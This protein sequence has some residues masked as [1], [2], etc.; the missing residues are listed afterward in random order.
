MIASEAVFWSWILIENI[1]AL[2]G[3]GYRLKQIEQ[4]MFTRMVARNEYCLGLYL[5]K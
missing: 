1:E 4:V 3:N 5:A 2:T